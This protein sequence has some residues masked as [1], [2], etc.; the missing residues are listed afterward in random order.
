MY[1][2]DIG[3]VQEFRRI[4]VKLCQIQRSKTVCPIQHERL[5]DNTLNLRQDLFLKYRVPNKSGERGNLLVRDREKKGRRSSFV[6]SFK[7]SRNVRCIKPAI[8]QFSIYTL[9]WF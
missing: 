1:F 5:R 3:L 8:K 9:S 6:L 2:N 4:C 7:L